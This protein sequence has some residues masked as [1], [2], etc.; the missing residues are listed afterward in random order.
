LAWVIL[1]VAGLL[2]VVWASALK[3][4]DEPLFLALTVVGLIASVGLLGV[5]VRE[6]P[7]GVA[8]GVWVGIGT[9]GTAIVSTTLLGERLSPL[10][11]GCL[12]LIAIGVG[13]LKLATPT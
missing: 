10:Q 6:L 7:V 5:A 9:I 12:A 13:G 8:Y 11:L 3:R 4:A 2:E 1:V